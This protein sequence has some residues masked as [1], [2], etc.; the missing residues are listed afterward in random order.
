[1][2]YSQLSRLGAWIVP[3]KF[4]LMRVALALAAI[5]AG[6][7]CVAAPPKERGG[8]V[9]RP[10]VVGHGHRIA[11]RAHEQHRNGPSNVLPEHHQ[12]AE[13]PSGQCESCQ[14]MAR[15]CPRCGVHCINGN[16]YPELTWDLAAPI[17]WEVFAQGEYVG[18]HRLP[19]VVEYRLRTDDV[20]EFV[21][22][23]TAEESSKKYKLQPGDQLRILLRNE[24]SEAPDNR[25]YSREWI[26]IEP[27]GYISLSFGQVRAAG[28]T[29]LQ[30]K[31]TL[32]KRLA[33]LP[34]ERVLNP[35]VVVTPASPRESEGGRPSI[36]TR[37]EE[38]RNTVDARYA[39][40]GGQTTRARAT[41]EG[42]VQLN[43]VGTAVTGGPPHRSVREALPHTAPAL[44]RAR[45]RLSGYGWTM[46]GRGR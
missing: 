45:N 39:V 3:A 40:T 33:E 41:P 46:R 12:L 15:S 20:L 17:P 32:E 8:V 14:P 34:D 26:M 1:M 44:S 28:L 13:S 25:V 2:A 38:L 27:D 30:L 23:L 10:G 21:F 22:R 6:G 7:V 18:P 16:C 11:R 4:R 29:F 43:A 42:T 37:L 35:K 36:N 19:H 5:T 24:V 31:E 9:L